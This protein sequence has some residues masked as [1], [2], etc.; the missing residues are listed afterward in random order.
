MEVGKKTLESLGGA[1]RGDEAGS[2]RDDAGLIEEG[3]AGSHKQGTRDAAAAAT[4]YE[5]ASSN[6]MDLDVASPEVRLTT[7]FIGCSTV[8]CLGGLFR[9]S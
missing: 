1:C 2:G 9:R 4:T 8:C 6:F 7:F 5:A 3:E